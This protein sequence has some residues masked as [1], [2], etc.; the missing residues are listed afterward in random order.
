[1]VAAI[2]RGQQDCIEPAVDELGAH[3]Q[4]LGLNIAAETP[5]GIECIDRISWTNT[6]CSSPIRSGQSR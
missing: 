5:V 4:Q 6:S 3:R 1:V 2:G